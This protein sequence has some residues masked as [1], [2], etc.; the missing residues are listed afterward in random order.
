MPLRIFA[1]RNR[2]GAYAMMLCVGT[3]VFSMF[4]FLTQFLQN[5]LG[6]SPVTTGVAF[7]PIMAGIVTAAAVTSRVLGRIGI[8]IPLLLGP[9]LV[10]VGPGLDVP[11]DLTSGYLDILGPLV[12][13]ALGMGMQFVSLTLTAVR[14]VAPS[15]TGLASALLNT[16][17]QLGGAL[18]LAVLAT[19]AINASTTKAR[20][21]TAAAHGHA[22]GLTHLI[23][24]ATGYTTAFEVAASI[25]LVGLVISVTVIR[26]PKPPPSAQPIL[27]VGVAAVPAA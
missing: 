15:E 1:N 27:A 22:A 20:S 10:F 16:A 23:A 17:Q 7:L 2:S 4:F 26:V 14:G 3:A 13:M 9:A 18:G 24:T 21:L 11:A 19:V 12:I 25:A 8:R 5:V 6:W